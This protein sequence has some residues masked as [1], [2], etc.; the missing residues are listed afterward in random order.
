MSPAQH[1]KQK[2]F[3]LGFDLVG[4][5]DP[6]PLDNQQLKIFNDWLALG[7]AAK[8]TYMR[9]NLD[10]RTNPAKILA[11]ARSVIC[12]AINYKP[13]ATQKQ[14]TNPDTHTGKVATYARYQDY[15]N[16]IKK[17]LRKLCD[18]LTSI[19]DTQPEFKICVDSAPLPER[20][21]AARA[22]L[23]F[24]G[25]NHMLTNPNLGPQILLGHII[26]DLQLDMD[27]P[28]ENHCAS[29]NK[30]IDACPTGA[31]QPDGHL[32]ANKCI[33]YLTIEHKDHIAPELAQKI[34]GRLFG[35]DQC[36]LACPYQQNAPECKNKQFKFCPDRAELDLRQILNM[37]DD[38][39]KEQFADS[40]LIR[41]GLQTLKRNA[42]ICLKN[43][44]NLSY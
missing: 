15:H 3:E 19:A 23:G 27:E 30:C 16:F 29:C 10:K 17:Q 42:K 39:F 31:L 12:V 28:V 37:T 36:L 13:P 43:L 22:G 6:A 1:I 24:I 7:Y 21:L 34:A 35:C 11:N 26:T 20:T 9:K 8:M 40:P 4:I 25:K 18:F 33:S 5:A 38:D 32:N 41:T 14:T 2:A 44:T